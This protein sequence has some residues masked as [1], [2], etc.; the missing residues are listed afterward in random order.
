MCPETWK[1]VSKNL[2]QAFGQQFKKNLKG[3]TLLRA[4]FSSL[5]PPL[6]PYLPTS[7]FGKNEKFFQRAPQFNIDQKNAYFLVPLPP[8]PPS[9]FEKN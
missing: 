8:L 3:T 7:S 1:H 5:P 2:P 9:P 4:S 6:P